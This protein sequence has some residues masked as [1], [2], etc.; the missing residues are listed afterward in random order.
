MNII[1]I[2]GAAGSGKDTLA[3]LIRNDGWE[4]LAYADALKHICIDYLGLSYDDAYTQEGKARFNEFWGMTNREILQKVGTD[5]MRNGFHKNVWIKI[6]ELKLKDM[7]SSGKKVIVTDV[8]FDNEAELIESL[9][10]CVARIIRNNE[11]G[12]SNKEQAHASE[13]GIDDKYVSFIVKNDLSKE[14]LKTEFYV[15]LSEFENRFSE[16]LKSLDTS[17]TFKKEFGDFIWD[18]KK[19]L[20]YEPKAFIRTENKNVRFEWFGSNFDVVLILI[21]K[22][23]ENKMRFS[24]V[25]NDEIVEST[26]LMICKDNFDFIN[27]KLEEEKWK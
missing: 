5:A 18:C 8:R 20:K 3:E 22:F 1:G 26:E 16:I 9:G 24:V 7:L 4:K 23:Q 25:K 14:L 12:L 2:T 11:N 6:A 19:F 27:E 21:T 10:G 13:R 17:D 15:K